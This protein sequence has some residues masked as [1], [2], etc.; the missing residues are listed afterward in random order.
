MPTNPK[1]IDK[2]SKWVQEAYGPLAEKSSNK[3]QLL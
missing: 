1:E 2:K 3:T